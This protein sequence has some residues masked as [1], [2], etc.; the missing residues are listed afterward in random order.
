[1]SPDPQGAGRFLNP[2]GP[3]P[4]CILSGRVCAQ[5]RCSGICFPFF[6]EVDSIADA[7]ANGVSDPRPLECTRRGGPSGG[8]S[9]TWSTL[10]SRNIAV[11]LEQLQVDEASSGA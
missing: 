9:V 11:V 5:A 10:T 4:L 3:M 1:M 2:C 8:A 7:I 6:M